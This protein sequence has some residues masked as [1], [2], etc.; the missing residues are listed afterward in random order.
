MLTVNEVCAQ[1]GIG[2]MTF[3][4]LVNTGALTAINV[5][6]AATAAKRLGERGPRRSLRVQQSEVT[7]FLKRNS[8]TA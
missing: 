2:R 5:N 1:I 4:K 7:A 8:V 3:Y 6:P